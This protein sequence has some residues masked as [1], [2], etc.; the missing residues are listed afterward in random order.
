[1]AHIA[2]KRFTYWGQLGIL[3]LLTGGGLIIGGIASI[4][5]LIGKFDIKDFRNFTS[6]GFMA[7]VLKP[8][9]AN[10]LRLMQ[11]ISTLFMFFYYSSRN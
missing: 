9:N 2:T 3:L 1:M 7:A 8:E 10:A 4:I 11:F 6:E 5:P